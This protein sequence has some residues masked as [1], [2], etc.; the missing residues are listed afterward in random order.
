[1]TKLS[2]DWWRHVAVQVAV[3]AAL[4]ALTAAG[5]IDWTTV[6]PLGALVPT[7]LALATEAV[8]QYLAPLAK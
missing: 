2:N 8:N 4:A 3:A 1:M 6:G 5:K 7:V